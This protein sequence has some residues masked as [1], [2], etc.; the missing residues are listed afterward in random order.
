MNL[1]QKSNLETNVMKQMPTV[2][3]DYKETTK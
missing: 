1:S 3:S 2:M